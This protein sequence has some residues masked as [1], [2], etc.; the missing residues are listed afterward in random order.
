[1]SQS[2]QKPQQKKIMYCMH[3]CGT[4]IKFSKYHRTENDGWIPLNMHGTVQEC[5]AK[6]WNKTTAATAA[7]N[8]RGAKQSV[9]NA[10]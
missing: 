9:N 8:S 7:N 10:K 1:M 3:G 6:K 2:Q 4:E 5:L